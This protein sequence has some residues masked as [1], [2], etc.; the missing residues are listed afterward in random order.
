MAQIVLVHG[1]LANQR[2]WNEIPAKLK[3]AGHVVTNITLPG[4]ANL[5]EYLSTQLSDYV[6]EVVDSLPSSGPAV[7]IGHSM[8]GFVISQTAASHPKR[9]SQLIYV[10][11]MMPS[12][13][14]TIAGLSHQA[15]T[16]L[17][18]IRAEFK[19][20]KVDPRAL[21]YQPPG[22]A[23]DAFVDENGMASVARHY[24]RCTADKILPPGF[25]D[26]MIGNWPGTTTADIATGHLPQYTASDDLAD[27]ILE[28][29]N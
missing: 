21:G 15:G 19:A 16:S 2:S 22:P 27:R 17:N 7:L 5:L 18:A 20:A 8:G 13:K 11:A 1:M 29:L 24:I 25:Q 26:Q 10:T 4:H 23:D 14:D 28:A 9:V 12:P 6:D 3:T